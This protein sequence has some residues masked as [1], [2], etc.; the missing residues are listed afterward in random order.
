MED[1]LIARGIVPYTLKWPERAKNWF[2]AHGGLISWKYAFREH[3]ESYRSRQRSKANQARQ[4]Q[5]LQEQVATSEARMAE[6]IDQR[7][8]LA[9]S[10]YFSEQ[11]AATASGPHVD[12]SPTQ[13]RSSVAFTEAA[14][15]GST[16]IIEE[17]HP[18]DDITG[19][20]PCELVTPVRNKLIVVAYGVAEQP[21]QGQ[22]IHGVEIQARYVKVGV[23]RVADGWED[24]ELEITGGDGKRNL[25]EAIHGWIQWPKRYI[26]ITT[27]NPPTLG[28]SPQGSRARSPT[29][30]ARAPSAR[31]DRSPSMSPVLEGIQA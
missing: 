19:I 5:E 16:K 7:V 28:S 1:E 12:V 29:P 18:M 24:L 3:I 30:S 4:L 8:A 14:A 15:G 10:K 21:M 26:S 11:A 22:T 23:D 9:L 2:Y 20:A 17:R 31:P 13:C 27:P 6:T 25:G